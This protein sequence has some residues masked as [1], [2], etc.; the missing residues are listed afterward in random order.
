M[1]ENF[2]AKDYRRSQSPF[3]IDFEKLRTYPVE[4]DIRSIAQIT[5]A[6]QFVIFN[7]GDIFLDIGPG[8]GGSFAVANK[9]LIN[10]RSIGIELNQGATNAFKRLYGIETLPSFNTFIKQGLKAKII[11][12]SHSLEHFKL[13]TL[14]DFLVNLKKLISNDGVVVIE[15][16]LIDFRKHANFRE[17]DAPHFLFFNLESLQLI[18]EKNH[19]KVLFINS[20]GYNY[21]DWFEK[22][23]LQVKKIKN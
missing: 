9:V 4:Y 13:S 7:T 23:N 19:W 12:L 16:P 10:P 3:Y 18:F 5:L 20:C 1:I 17:E 11:L 6:K 15:V 22:I 21:D 8:R 14:E 2:Y